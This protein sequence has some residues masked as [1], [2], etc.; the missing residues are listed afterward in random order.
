[1]NSVVV[2]DVKSNVESGCSN[3]VYFKHMWGKTMLP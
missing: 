1:M 2:A 3:D